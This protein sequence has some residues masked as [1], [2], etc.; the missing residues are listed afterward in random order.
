MFLWWLLVSLVFKSCP[1][2][3]FSFPFFFF[4][5]FLHNY[6]VLPHLCV[7]TQS[8]G[9]GEDQVILGAQCPIGQKDDWPQ[10]SQEVDS[11]GSKLWLFWV[12]GHLPCPCPSSAHH[13]EGIFFPASSYLDGRTPSLPTVPPNSWPWVGNWRRPESWSLSS[14]KEPLQGLYL[15]WWTKK[16]CLHHSL[17]WRQFL[18]G[19]SE[20]FKMNLEY[21]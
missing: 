20:L 10:C 4:F 17:S 15:W 18:V 9:F 12:R 8:P 7:Q 14:C 19:G 21:P 3:S 5:F 2:F 6:N 13:P 16:S 1:C 11:E